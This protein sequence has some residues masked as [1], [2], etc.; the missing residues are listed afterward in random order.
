MQ[1]KPQAD[2][3]LVHAIRQGQ[4]FVDWNAF[5]SRST[6]DGKDFVKGLLALNES[7]R[8]GAS[9]ADEVKGHRWFS[10]LN[11]NRVFLCS[12]LNL[13]RVFQLDYFFVVYSLTHPLFA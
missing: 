2:S 8:L 6:E 3:E 12:P 13:N 10:S 11:L 7:Q 1:A 4:S 5:A 9:S